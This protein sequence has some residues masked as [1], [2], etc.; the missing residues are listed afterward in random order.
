[1]NC[2][3][4]NEVHFCTPDDALVVRNILSFYIKILS[5]FVKPPSDTLTGS[6]L[7]SIFI[8]R[9]YFD[10]A[11]HSR[12]IQFCFPCVILPSKFL[13]LTLHHVEHEKDGILSFFFCVVYFC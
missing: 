6:F 13:P 9:R 10:R 3:S 7:F 11:I 2:C 12:T 8:V 1:M 5:Q 4:L